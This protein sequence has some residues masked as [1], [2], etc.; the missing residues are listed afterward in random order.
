MGELTSQ[1]RLQPS[2]LD[3][4]TD[5]A[6]M[7]PDESR[8]QRVISAQRLR[9]YVIRDLSWLLNCTH[10]Q[11]LQSFDVAPRVATSVL[12]YGIP[13]FTGVARSGVDAARSDG[14]A[15][16]GGGEGPELTVTLQL[17][18]GLSADE[19]QAAVGH[20]QQQLAAQPVMADAVDS[21]EVRLTA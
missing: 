16:R 17:R 2:L 10:A 11:A 5:D 1:E 14:A 8:E 7:Q 12:N 19:V 21:I 18:A 9:E 6:P 3:R 15:L 4:L 13:D 20:Y